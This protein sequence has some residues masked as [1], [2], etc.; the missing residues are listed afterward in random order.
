MSLS[1]FNHAKITALSVVVP[2]NEINIYDEARYYD[3]NIKRIDRMRKIVGFWKRR[4][5]DDDVTPSDLAIGAAENLFAKY[6]IDKKSIDALIF[7]H[8]KL[9]Y[10]GPVDSYEIHYKLGLSED[11]ICTSVLQGCAGWVWGVFLASQ[12]IQSRSVKRV[13]LLNADT[14]AV[15]IDQSDRNTAPLFGDAGSAT[16]VDYTEEDR[17]SFF[18]IKTISS[19]YDTII[20]PAGGCRL[21]Y[22]F[23]LSQDHPFN[24]PIV[25]KFT[26]KAGYK[27]RLLRGHMDGDPVF[28]FTMNQ[29]P[30]QIKE[31]LKYC[32]LKHEDIAKCCL[33]QAN[34]QIVQAVATGAGFR[35]ES[36]PYGVFEKYGNNTMCTVPTVLSDLYSN[37]GNSFES[38]PY[39]CSGFGNGLVIATAILDL[40]DTISTGVCDY[41]KPSDFMNRDQWVAFWKAKVSGENKC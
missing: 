7:V 39:L 25:E 1:A 12:M 18:G 40:H 34:K 29:V 32:N 36:T 2:K 20:C 28:E 31:V 27:T 24:K 13:L 9:S 35:L 23:D 4:V 30:A 15:G 26:S 17:K 21:R 11:C 14:P 3:N 19:G 37:N 22:D 10:P 8:Q 41:E 33:H 6:N 38:K 16:L 5:A